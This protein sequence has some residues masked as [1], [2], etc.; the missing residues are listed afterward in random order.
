MIP[1]RVALAL[2]ADDWWLRQ[3]IV[4]EKINCMPESVTDRC[5]RSHEMIYMLTKSA[6]YYYD[7]DAIKEK[8]SKWEGVPSGWNTGPGD[9]SAIAHN[10][11]KGNAKTFRGGGK[12]TKGQSFDNSA[13]AERESH[14]NIPNESGLRN[15][16]SVWKIATNPYGKA[17]FATFPPDLV[18][19]CI[20]AGTKANDLVLDPFSGSGTV[21]QVCA[22]LCRD[23]IG[24]ELN[25]E[26]AGMRKEERSV[27]TMEL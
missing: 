12:Y 11:A 17:H 10:R 9:H 5:T 24:I 21:G 4:W 8:A 1:A 15:K 18:K 25:P 22:E 19:S 7:A 6:Q 2:Q 26:Y 3:E 14:G 16:R 27:L 23:Y 20:L 13:P